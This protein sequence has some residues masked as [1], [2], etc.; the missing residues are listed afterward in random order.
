MDY[1]TYAYLREDGT[2][3]YIGKGRKYRPYSKN[4]LFKP[5]SKDRILI[6]KAGLTEEEAI[7]HEIYMIA[8]LGRK[9][10]NSGILRN[11]TNGGDG[12]SG[13]SHTEEAKKS[14]GKKNSAK[15]RT[16]E[17]RAKIAE[18]VKGFSWYN[19]GSENVQA[20]KHPGTGWKEGR[21]LDWDTPRNSGMKW[22]HKDGV[23][24]MFKENPGDGW[25]LGR[26]DIPTVNNHTNKGKRWYN[27]GTINKMFVNPPEGW[28][29]GMI[30]R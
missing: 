25:I 10:N 30:K 2:P 23:R 22:Y 20:R 17:T 16:K 8:V 4:R 7:K 28:T 15:T 27:D 6:L 9:D 29:P 21:I 12:I 5:P 18:A 26:L 13:Y 1:C 14:I 11:L 24:K 19:N 3:Y